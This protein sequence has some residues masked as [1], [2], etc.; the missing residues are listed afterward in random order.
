MIDT[1]RTWRCEVRKRMQFKAYESPELP[2]LAWCARVDRGKDEITLV[3]GS[4]VETRPHAFVEGAWDGD[5]TSLDFMDATIVCGTGGRAED[6]QVRFSA[7]TDRVCPLF[8][9][10]RG[11]SVFVSQSPTF[12]MTMS[13][14]APDD[15]YPFYGHDFLSIGRQG[16]YCQSGKLRTR[17]GRSLRVHFGTIV[18]IDTGLRITFSPH[19]LCEVPRDFKSYKSLLLEGVRLVLQNAGDS[20]RRKRYTP[21]AAISKGYDSNA[22]AALASLA[23]CEEA[24]SFR[25][26]RSDDPQED[27]GVDNARDLGMSCAEYDRWAY[28]DLKSPDAEFA[29]FTTSTNVPLAAAEP[30]L[31]GR[32]L[33]VGQSGDAVWNS[34]IASLCTNMSRPFAKFP[35]VGQL[36]FRLRVGYQLLPV[37][38]IAA[39]HNRAIHDISVSEEM[40][41]WVIGGD[42]DRPIPRRIAEETGLPRERFATRKLGTGHA[43]FTKASGFSTQALNDYL[44]F[45]NEKRAAAPWLALYW[46]MRARWRTLLFKVV[47]KQ[48]LVESSPLQRRFPFILNARPL[49]GT[50]DFMFAFQWA[51]ARMRS[52]YIPANGVA[53]ILSGD[54]KDAHVACA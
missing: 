15:L 18:T 14:E 2:A 23:G 52:R 45:V 38:V 6:S 30:L 29:Y 5:F 33:I 26:S 31:G 12:V 3:H 1:P 4:G 48:R 39:R 19:R 37:A 40:R 27:S 47:S 54:R 21:L 49:S 16:L 50:D 28:L 36:E 22:T 13:G 44:R 53:G 51:S 34:K 11:D 20:A 7:S 46:R 9:I 17:S 43:H 8:S 24:V 35:G 41:P 10:A 25:D 32:V 42:Y